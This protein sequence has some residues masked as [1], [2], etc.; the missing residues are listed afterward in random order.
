MKSIFITALVLSASLLVSPVSASAT[1]TDTGQFAASAPAAKAAG[2]TEEKK[3]CRQLPSSTS[4][5]PQRACLTARQ[6]KQVDD[7]A[8]R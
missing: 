4:R 8:N 5:L 1:G 2:T 6:W 3:I 7:D